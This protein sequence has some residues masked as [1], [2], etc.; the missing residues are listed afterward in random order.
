MN[1]AT[2]LACAALIL[3]GCTASGDDKKSLADS[4][5][6]TSHGV[7]ADGSETI[8]GTLDQGPQVLTVGTSPINPNKQAAFCQDEVAF[9]FKAEPQQVTTRERVVAADGSTTIEVM[10]DKGMAGVK[11]FKCRLDAS[12]RFVD[13]IASDAAL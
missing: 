12:N 1:A 8:D 4:P 13:V 5:A 6:G 3:A 10:V 9:R 7:A 2:A 11:T